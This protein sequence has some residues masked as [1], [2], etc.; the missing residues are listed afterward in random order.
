MQS[1][2]SA[3]GGLANIEL[4]PK[5]PP[6]PHLPVEVFTGRGFRGDPLGGPR[7]LTLRRYR[8]STFSQ[9]RAMV[10]EDLQIAN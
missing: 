5:R 10:F 7:D 2:A 6:Q 3:S 8:K 1:A 4:N 9:L